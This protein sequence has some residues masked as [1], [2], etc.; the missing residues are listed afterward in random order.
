MILCYS[1]EAWFP[2]S[3]VQSVALISWSA[4]GIQTL[5]AKLASRTQFFNPS[6]PFKRSRVRSK[7]EYF[8]YWITLLWDMYSVLDTSNDITV[9]EYVWVTS[10]A[11]SVKNRYTQAVHTLQAHFPTQLIDFRPD[12]NTRLKRHKR[13]HQ[14]IEIPL[15]T[16]TPQ[17]SSCSVLIQL[18]D[19]I[20]W[21]IRYEF[22]REHWLAMSHSDHRDQL[23]AL[24]KEKRTR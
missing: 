23:V 15:I 5:E 19:L 12:R 7:S 10:E 20:A 21:I 13:S 2:H 17:D 14:F 16:V 3:E 18:C 6:R 22:Q 11:V 4:R 1:D 8:E 24:Y 9:M